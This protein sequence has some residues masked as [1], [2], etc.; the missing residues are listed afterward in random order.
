MID[1]LTF[2]DFARNADRS[3][4]WKSYRERWI[5]H[6]IAIE[7]A[8]TLGIRRNRSVIEI[9]TF[10]AQ[11]VPGSDTM[12]LPRGSWSLPGE[13]P[14]V[15]H[16]ARKLPWPIRAGRYQLLVALRVW[17]HLAPAQRACF[18]EARRVAKNLIICCPE[19]EVVGRG[20]PREDWIE[21]NG[22]PPLI[23]RKTDGWGIVYLFGGHR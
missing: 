10:G 22:G 23:E 1:F 8:K 19:Q 6:E 13:V 12:D 11:V 7:I 16:D 2:D 15:A 18:D 5:Y 9:G 14:T 20:I 17:H 21:W 4:Q 3:P